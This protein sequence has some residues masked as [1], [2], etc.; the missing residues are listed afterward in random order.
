MYKKLSKDY[1]TLVPPPKKNPTQLT[2]EN[3]IKKKHNKKQKSYK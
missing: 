3:T 2:K 1:Q